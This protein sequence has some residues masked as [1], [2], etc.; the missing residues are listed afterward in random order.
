[1]VGD[2]LVGT[3][4]FAS[5]A[6]NPQAESVYQM[7]CA[8]LLNSCSV[9][10]RP[11][12]EPKSNSKGG[13]DYGEVEL[14]EI[15]VCPLPANPDALARALGGSASSSVSEEALQ[16]RVATIAATIAVASE[17]GAESLRRELSK[18]NL[19][20]AEYDAFM[21]AIAEVL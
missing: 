11:L 21:G 3:I 7:L 12:A 19:S 15:S 14:M 1:M 2:E 13:L 5:A 4:E 6:L 20:D 10:F 17:E 18:L 8:G 9:G 16:R